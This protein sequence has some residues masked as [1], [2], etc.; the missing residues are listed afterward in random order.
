MNALAV[1]WRKVASKTRREAAKRLAR[2]DA[3]I[4]PNEPLI[5]FTFDDFPASALRIGGEILHAHGIAATFY[6][7]FGIIGQDSPCGRIFAAD[8][9]ERLY[10]QGHELGCHTYHH[11][12]STDTPA[13][14]FEQSV[15]KNQQALADFSNTMSM[16]SHSYPIGC[17]RV[18]TKRRVQRLFDCCRGGGQTFN[19]GNTDLNYLNAFF[20]EQARGNLKAVYN[21]IDANR[22]RG[23][24][25]IFATHD[26]DENPSRFGCTPEFFSTVVDYCSGSNSRICFVSEALPLALKS[27]NC[28]AV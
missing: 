25:L 24:W 1:I 5:S 18:S 15:L 10:S 8:D 3:I 16:R 26:V 21:V 14:Q 20:L 9:L 11:L 28:N 19:R 17:P 23:G 7:S 4:E 12:H 27:N 13:R 22:E 2:R 6:T